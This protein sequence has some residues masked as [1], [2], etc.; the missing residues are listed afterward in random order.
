MKVLSR[1]LICSCCL[2]TVAFSMAFVMS[3]FIYFCAGLIVTPNPFSAI[4]LMIGTWFI[5][6]MVIV[7]YAACYFVSAAVAIRHCARRWQVPYRT[8][9]SF[10][11][12]LEDDSDFGWR[13]L[14]KSGYEEAM[15]RRLLSG[16]DAS[17]NLESF[18]PVDGQP[19]S[20]QS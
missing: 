18:N 15:V 12:A 16:W 5:G 13:Q 2:T 19:E 1:F 8:A 14:S 7:L 17:H 11:L 20:P 9:E 6:E 3:A 10:C 4:K